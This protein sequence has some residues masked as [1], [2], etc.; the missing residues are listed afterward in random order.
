[1][2]DL[3]FNEFTSWLFPGD[4]LPVRN[5]ASLPGAAVEILEDV[6]CGTGVPVKWLKKSARLVLDGVAGAQCLWY[7]HGLEGELV[8]AE[9][10]KNK[11][12]LERDLD[13]KIGSDNYNAL[14][15]IVV[16]EEEKGVRPEIDW[17]DGYVT[18]GKRKM[19]LG[20]WLRKWK[21]SKELLKAF[22]TRELPVWKWR[23]STH[24]FDVLTMS[25]NRPWVSCMRPG[26]A[27]ELGPLTDMAAGTAV[28]FFHR[29]G[30]KVPCGRTL[31]R[32]ALKGQSRIMLWS[33]HVYGCGP[34]TIDVKE[35][36]KDLAKKT[37]HNIPVGNVRL[38]P[39]GKSGDALTRNIYSD[40]DREYCAQSNEAYDKAYAKLLDAKWPPSKLDLGDLPMKAAEVKEHV[41][42]VNEDE[43]LEYARSAFENVFD[44]W[45]WEGTLEQLH[46]TYPRGIVEMDLDYLKETFDIEEG[47]P[48][49][50]EIVDMVEE[51][52]DEMIMERFYST[53]I[54][55]L[56][57]KPLDE[58]TEYDIE[59]DLTSI[60]YYRHGHHDAPPFRLPDDK[61]NEAL[62]KLWEEGEVTNWIA[63]PIEMDLS[64][65]ATTAENAGVLVGEIEIDPSARPRYFH[66]R[67]F[68]LNM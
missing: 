16:A 8:A 41:E 59:G 4:E 28:M 13:L 53:P 2:A 63:A 49:Y 51:R 36:R 52:R 30:A 44:S 42:A 1:M 10:P 29:P 25:F 26:G 48:D 65:V 66:P 38:C 7:L 39:F 64:I 31:L 58:Y 35:L 34:Q 45:G 40:V 60:T 56:L 24:P 18:L 33:G 46:R 61:K 23:I 17:S 37:R 62:E 67:D 32:P 27:A 20:K 57:I 5:P 14:L 6:S 12:G 3:T 15:G 55:V 11:Y 68:G 47:D 50:E 43:L 54:R 21:A 19:K 9:G 22:E